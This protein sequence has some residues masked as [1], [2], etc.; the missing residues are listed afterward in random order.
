MRVLFVTAEADPFVKTG[1]LGEVAG[2]LPVALQKQG[3]DVRVIMPKYSRI[4]EKLKCEIKHITHFQVPLA[5]RKQYCGL[6]EA[7]YEGIQYYFIDNEYYFKRTGIYGD[8]DEAEQYTFFCRSVL[9]SLTHLPGFKPNIIHCNDWHT[10]MIPFMLKEFYGREPL[11]YDIKTVFTIHNLKYQGIFTK[12]VLGNILGLGDEFFTSETLEFHG[13]VNFMKAALLYADQITT[14]SPTYAKEI[15]SP[16]YGEKLEGLLKKRSET[17]IGIL[18]GIDYEKY[19]PQTDTY[20]FVPYQA[21]SR[22]KDANK[23]QLQS[24][25]GL[26]V[27]GD[28]PLLGIVSRLVDQKG[29]DLLAHVLEEI[30]D[31]DIQMVVLGS[32]EQKYE[33]MFRFFAAKY[34][35]KLAINI[36]FSDELAHKIYAGADIFL[37][38]SL[39]EPCGIAQMIAMR[40]GTVPVVRET[41]GLRDTVIPFNENTEQ[42]NGFSFPNYNAHEL[43][44]TVQSAVR[45]FKE[46]PS[47]WD[48]I[49]ENACQ[50]NFSWNRS[51]LTYIE[52]YQS[53]LSTAL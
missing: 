14:V 23:K 50:S 19:D 53:V 51:A 38:P 7:T 33:E 2:S 1:G 49:K 5:W 16:Y 42:G 4:S 13:A 10:A 8:Y 15:Q 32:G 46:K 30:L 44:F 37:M 31:Q 28:I 11:G 39:F 36:M 27:R 29:L 24:L 35:E 43:L 48:R 12:D 17:L 21:S 18:N 52:L 3:V 47:V 45:L 34:P 26:P 25:M 20:I 6:E 22:E 40:Y 9:E 41:G